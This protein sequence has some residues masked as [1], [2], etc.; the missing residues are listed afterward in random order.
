MRKTLLI[1]L[2]CIAVQQQSVAQQ[3]HFMSIFQQHNSMY[4]P[5]AAGFTG[6][7]VFG[8]SY[9]S[10]WSSFP[11][12]P[13]TFM[14]YGDAYWEKKN[15]GFAGYVYKDITGPTSRTGVQLAYSYHVKTGAHSKLGL[16]LELRG[17][18]YAI[19]KS[20]ISDA[21]GSDLV[22]AGNNTSFKLD[23]GAGIYFSDG[24]FSAGAAVSQL[25]QSKLAFNDVPNAK[26]R[27]KLY[28]HYVANA[29]YVIETGG[30]THLTPN[31]MV[32]IIPN[33]PTEFDFGCKVDYQDRIWW[34]LSWRVKHFWSLQAGFKL[35]DQISFTYAYDYYNEPF[36]DYNTGNNGHEIGLRFNLKKK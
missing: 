14:A 11:G 3:L 12:N 23:G 19:D 21:L 30:N 15:S 36:S 2:L 22:L 29:S 6:Y 35:M 1:A 27:A 33:A 24:K 26:E 34:A 25:I 7:P 4:N 5:A 16:G 32:R 10:M 18:Q 20:K 31:A 9:R 8:A 28:R 13:R 17:L